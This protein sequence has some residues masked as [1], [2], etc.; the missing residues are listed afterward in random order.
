[1]NESTLDRSHAVITMVALMLGVLM[2]AMDTTVIGMSMPAIVHDLSG[3]ERYSW[4]FTAYLLCSTLAVPIFGSLA[5]CLG[6]RMVFL[7]GIAEFIAASMLCGFSADMGQLI[8]FR[9]LQGLGGG[10]IISSAFALV[11][12]SFHGRE[13]G[14]YMGFV[15]A[16]FGLASVI[17]PS[18]GGLLTDNFGWRWTFYVN[19]P[20]GIIAFLVLAVGLAGKTERRSALRLDL[21]G[22]ALFVASLVPL[23]LALARG[24]REVSWSSPS[25]I[26]LLVLALLMGVSFIAVERRV[27]YPLLP[28]FLFRERE[29]VV[30]AAATFFSNAAFYAGILFLPLYMQEVMH[31]SVSLSALAITPMLLSYTAA[32]ILGGQLHSKLGRYRGLSVSATLV[33]IVSMGALTLISPALGFL[34][35]IAAMVALGFGL[36]LT[37]P[38]FNIAAQNCFGSEHIGIVTSSIQFFRYVGSA[39]GSA[40][41]GTL[42]INNLTASIAGID[43]GQTPEAIRKTLSDPNV[44]MNSTAIRGIVSRVPAQYRAY[45][46]TLT[47]KIDGLLAGAIHTVF[48]AACVFA[49]LSFFSVLA[50]R[51]NR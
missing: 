25:I 50:Y 28:P 17:G 16:M 27:K 22:V 36:G 26:G 40:V 42:M 35:V 21:P 14:K 11:G 32:N 12:E 1:M 37:T 20:L 10:V 5:D 39:V 38:I 3:M 8:F 33:A 31:T 13:R 47:A 34:P 23:M 18:V 6:R 15:G 4:P 49:V 7:F 46:D 48:F 43:W 41:F 51:K 24:G 29:F 30:S 2:S 9:G 44:L 19:L 45:M